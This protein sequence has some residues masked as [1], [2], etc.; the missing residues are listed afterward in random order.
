MKYNTDRKRAQFLLNNMIPNIS[1][2]KCTAAD[3]PEHFWD[4]GVWSVVENVFLDT[5]REDDDEDGSANK[6]RKKERD[7]RDESSDA[8]DDKKDS[9]QEG[10][11][12]SSEITHGGS[13][14]D[15]QQ[16]CAL[17]ELSDYI[18]HDV[19]NEMDLLGMTDDEDE[20]ILIVRRFLARH[21]V[22]GIVGAGI[23]EVGIDCR[24]PPFDE[25]ACPTLSESNILRHNTASS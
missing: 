14:H 12:A 7:P 15:E 10:D 6:K 24:T 1:T 13:G 21:I 19:G 17:A 20:R 22:P 5:I 4:R 16:N 9:N 2:N 8:H 11:N 23:S 18:G 3:L 25:I